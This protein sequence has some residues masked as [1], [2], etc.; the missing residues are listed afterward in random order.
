M[1]SPSS[2]WAVLALAAALGCTEKSAPE[3]SA[4]AT[5]PATPEAPS[6]KAETPADA[7]PHEDVKSH[8]VN[9]FARAL[10]IKDAV[11]KGDLPATREPAKWLAEHGAPPDSPDEWVPFITELRQVAAGADEAKDITAVAAALS[12]VAVVCGRCHTENKIRVETK[13]AAKPGADQQMLLHAWATDQMW[14]G[15][16]IPDQA[17]WLAGLETLADGANLFP[18]EQVK[19]G[20]DLAALAKSG[21][22][23]QDDLAK[24]TIFG[25]IMATCASCHASR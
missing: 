24:A 17:R 14:E 18:K 1:R 3:P 8:M 23:A 9:H 12:R 15:L 21:K 2:V 7:A 25:K 4:P 19:L 13:S 5:P 11:I 20:K 22:E 16:V 6:A 10:A